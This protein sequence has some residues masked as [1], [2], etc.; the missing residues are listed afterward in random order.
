M[1]LTHILL[2]SKYFIWVDPKANGIVF[3]FTFYL[4][5]ADA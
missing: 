2:T 4:F 3:D 5:I 1:Y